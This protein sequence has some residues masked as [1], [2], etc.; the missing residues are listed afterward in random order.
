TVLGISNAVGGFA[1]SLDQAQDISVLKESLNGVTSG[2]AVAFDTTLVALVMSLIV[3]FPTTSMQ[4]SEEDLLNWVDE[5]CNENLVKRLNDGP[6][7][8]GGVGDPETIRAAVGE[9]MVGHH[10]ELQ[11]WTKKLESIG[12]SVTKQVVKG[13]REI[14]EESLR[15]HHAE[16]AKAAE[17]VAAMGDRQQQLLDQIQQVQELIVQT[18]QGQIHEMELAMAGLAERAAKV[19]EQVAGSMTDS[20]D[21]MRDCFAS[22]T[23]GLSSLNEVL[24][25]L[26]EKQVVVEVAASPPR[27]GWSWFGRGNGG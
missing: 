22:M 3:M 12:A 23:Q 5:Y 9:A 2:L 7:D 13:W 17:T 27:R 21:S 20:A 24:A 19:Q 18:Q 8:R 15:E 26:G 6:Q 4:Q 1:G 11:A 25:N 16:L 14:Q 10:A